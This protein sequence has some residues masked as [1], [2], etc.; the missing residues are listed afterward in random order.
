MVSPSLVWFRKDLRLSDNPALDAALARGGPILCV[1]V[2]DEATEGA[3]PLGGAAGW[4]LH[5][6]LAALDADIKARSGRLILRRGDASEILPAL[7][8]ET[9]AGAVFWN[10]CYE[11]DAI[12]RD[13]ALKERFR[14]EER[15]VGSFNG[16]LL[17]EPWRIKTKTGGPYGVFTPFWRAECAAGDP[18]QPVAAPTNLPAPEGGPDSDDLD[19]WRLVPSAPDWAAGFA[20]CWTPGEAGARARLDRFLSRHAGDYEDTRNRPDDPDGTSRL[21]PHLAF[22]ELSAREIWHI[23]RDRLAAS[24]GTGEDGVWAFLRELGW[25]DFN[26]NLLFHNPGLPAANYNGKFDAFPWREDPEALKAWQAGR[27]GYPMVDAGMRELWHTGFMH[28]RVRMIVASFLVKH[29]LIHWREG[30]AWFRDTLVDADLASNTANWQW[31]AGCGADAAP[32]FRIF[33]PITQGEKF[34]PQGDYVRRWVPELAELPLKVLH[35]PWTATGD[36]LAEAGV[37]LGETYPKPIVD[38]AEARKRALAAY[39][40]V[41]GAA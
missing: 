29:L 8:E 11:P 28:N 18:P 25:R 3:A 21:S 16:T 31:T 2:L 34:D 26:Y 38:H 35:K 20:E 22:G 32:Y 33:N 4:W 24:G 7:C 13:K 37:R 19:G 40:V 5:H 27:T 30:E 17:H 1:F 23:A 6:S 12:A 9:E 36:V 41:K 15:D 39:E 10:R 14:Q